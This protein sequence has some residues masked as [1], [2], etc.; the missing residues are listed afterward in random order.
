[1]SR[2]H[3]SLLPTS[4][5]LAAP[6]LGTSASRLR[7]LDG[8]KSGRKVLAGGSQYGHIPYAPPAPRNGAEGN[9]PGGKPAGK[10]EGELHTSD[11]TL[12]ETPQKAV[13]NTFHVLSSS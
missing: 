8:H 1:M 7:W 3:P 13:E 4:T 11:C 6:R 5:R 9:Y 12:T 2:S 10:L